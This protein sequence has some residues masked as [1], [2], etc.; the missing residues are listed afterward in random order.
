MKT[1][2]YKDAVFYQIYPR[3]FCDSNGDGIGDIQGIISKLDY[4]KELGINAVWLSPVYA[5][6]NDDNGYDISDY[7]AINPEFGTLEDWK[8]MVAGMHERGIRL[9]MDLV[10]NHT[11]DEH[12]WFRESRKSKDNPY[13]DYYIWRKGRGKD[14]KKPPNN[15]TSRFT[16]SAWKYD[17]ATDEWYLHLFSEKQ[18]DLNWDNPKVRKEVIDICNY[19]LSMGVD[20]FRCD[21]ITYISKA[22]G[23]PMGKFNPV[24]C[25]DEHFVLGP[26]IHEY[27]NEINRESWSKYDTMIVG[28]AIGCK[29]GDAASIIAEE[30]NEL[31]SAIT[32]ELMEVDMKLNFFPVKLRLPK[33]KKVISAWQN[34]PPSCWNTLYLENHDQPRSVSRYGNGAGIYRKELAKMLA[35]TLHFLRGTP[36]VYQGQ[37]IGMT[38]IAL[39]EEEYIDI[40]APRIFT[41]IRKVFPP[42]MPLARWAM[43]KRARDHARTPMQWSGRPGAGFT[44]GKPWMKINPN[45]VDINV[46][47]EKKN[48][49][50]V[51][52]FYKK[53]IS[54]RLG[55]QILRDGSYKEYF[56]KNRS[57]FV[58]ERA[59][60]KQRYIV[61]CNFKEKNVNL[62]AIDMGA[63]G[64]E[65]VLSNYKDAPKAFTDGQ[66][67]RPYEARVYLQIK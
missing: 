29:V 15:W 4:L 53:L 61:I 30:K 60:G 54:L 23:L 35:V 18:P 21:V 44:T 9:V 20:G 47:N 33:F 19:W 51:L 13:R 67:L 27:L 48:P 45:H 39:K 26:H 32:F 42:L 56:P 14:G 64:A 58:Y 65:L 3:S 12:F 37:E 7:K 36:Y 22:E 1:R 41:I 62:N 11:S 52:N 46:E 63:R 34:L 25:G 10:V 57:L 43:S 55:N 66:T 31:D 40:M 24:M 16:G 50:S 5:S 28:E 2:W 38:N 49:S 59:L 8:Q 17:A 6:P